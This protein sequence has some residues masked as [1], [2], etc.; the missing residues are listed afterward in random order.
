M[1][2]PGFEPMTSWSQRN[3][4]TAAPGFPSK[5]V[6]KKTDTP[7]AIIHIYTAYTLMKYNPSLIN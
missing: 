3:R 5:I 1:L 2:F 7:E 4:F 6:Q